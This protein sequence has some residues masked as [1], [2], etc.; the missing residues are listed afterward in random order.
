LAEI[1][2]AI[3]ALDS[4]FATE[5]LPPKVKA[6]WFHEPPA[7]PAW[8]ME[9]SEDLQRREEMDLAGVRWP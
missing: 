1:R 7:T 4:P 2:A 9:L 6:F 3:D 5:M 8:R